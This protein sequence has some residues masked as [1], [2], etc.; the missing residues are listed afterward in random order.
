MCVDDFVTGT[1]AG[2]NGHVGGLWFIG[3]MLYTCIL[4]TVTLKAALSVKFVAFCSFIF[5]SQLIY[6][7]CQLFFVHKS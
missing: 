4:S 6:F 3:T 7:P 5:T 1:P 2:M